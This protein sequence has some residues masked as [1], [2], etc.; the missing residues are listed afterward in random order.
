MSTG[1]PL[2]KISDP[3]VAAGPSGCRFRTRLHLSDTEAAA[4][5]EIGE[6]LGGWYRRELAGRV[7]LGRIDRDGHKQWRATRKQ[8]LTSVSSSRWAG[9]I[10]RAGAVRGTHLVVQLLCNLV[11]GWVMVHFSGDSVGVSSGG[12]LRPGGAPVVGGPPR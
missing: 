4:L 1:K 6:F 8:T 2:R 11:I 9:A 10:T 7:R 12:T 3:L 5:V